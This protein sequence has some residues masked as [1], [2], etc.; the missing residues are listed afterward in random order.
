MGDVF[1]GYVY[2]F[3]SGEEWTAERGEGV[4]VDGKPLEDEGPKEGVEMLALEATR[5]DLVAG[6]V[7]RMV[8][9]AG[10]FRIFGSLALVL[11]HLAAGRVDAVCSLRPVRSVDIAAGQLLVRERG[12]RDRSA[13]RFAVRR[14]RARPREALVRGG[15]QDTRS[16]RANLARAGR[17]SRV[18]GLP[19]RRS[20]SS[21][22]GHAS[23]AA[24]AFHSGAS[25][26]VERPAS[27][28]ARSRGATGGR[29]PLLV[30]VSDRILHVAA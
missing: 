1:F 8:G 11:C 14:C 9:V 16:L 13:A 29:C 18:A 20:W 15:R 17:L 30:V 4:R 5:P 19:C 27:R 21:R 12:S 7:A 6:C 10:G 3:G 24:T 28:I 2:D 25:G 26:G 22:A 23:S